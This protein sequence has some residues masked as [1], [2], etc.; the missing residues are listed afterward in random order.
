MRV[1]QSIEIEFDEGGHS[2]VKASEWSE[3]SLAL[4]QGEDTI[5]VPKSDA[6]AF[7]EALL[8]WIS[9]GGKAA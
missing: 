4:Q 8:A 1:L 9:T 7:G 6:A 3:D 2:N 5:L